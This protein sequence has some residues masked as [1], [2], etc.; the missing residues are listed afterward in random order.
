MNRAGLLELYDFDGW[1]WEQIMAAVLLEVDFSRPAPASGWP[2]LRDC[3]SHLAFGYNVWM[4]R[5]DGHP[6]DSF[7]PGSA[8]R[9]AVEDYFRRCRER[10]RS[11]LESLGTEELDAERDIDTRDGI[12]KYTVAEVL[13][14]ILVHG[15]AHHGDVSTLFYQL[16]LEMPM[17][18]YRFYV[19]AKR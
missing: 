12:Y 5:L 6:V 1:A 8:D 13:S 2:A 16:G 7:D 10:F 9:A 15:R 4:T 11:F 19:D 17:I 18:D 3:L 14:H